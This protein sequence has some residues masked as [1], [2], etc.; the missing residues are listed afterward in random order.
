MVKLHEQAEGADDAQ[1]GQTGGAS[2]AH[3]INHHEGQPFIL[4]GLN[5]G[6]LTCAEPLKK[7]VRRGG[8]QRPH[9]TP[10]RSLHARGG[11][12]LQSTGHQFRDDLGGNDAPPDEARE[13]SK[14]GNAATSAMSGLLLTTSEGFTG[15]GE[16]LR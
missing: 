2:S 15:L 8:T 7:R 10:R 11:V 5:D 9:F 6:G 3:F 14:S 13:L 4:C 16:L 1:P 12:I